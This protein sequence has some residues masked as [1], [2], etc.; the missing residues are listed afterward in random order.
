MLNYSQI[1]MK[2]RKITLTIPQDWRLGQALM[3][4]Y[5]QKWYNTHFG[6]P[7]EKHSYWNIWEEDENK[8]QDKINKLL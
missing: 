4:A 6:I 8:I 5:R 2:T 7:G 1:R 3:N